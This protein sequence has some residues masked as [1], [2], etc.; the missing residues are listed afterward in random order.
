MDPPL[1]TYESAVKARPWH[2]IEIGA[3][4]YGPFADELT[5]F[6]RNTYLVRK[7]PLRLWLIINAEFTREAQ[8]GISQIIVPLNTNRCAQVYRHLCKCVHS[9][10][11]HPQIYEH[12]ILL[13]CTFRNLHA[14]LK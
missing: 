7:I 8:E 12:F 9:C 6:I 10:K 1:H 11:C 3:F 2:L 5:E 14:F 4:L 13:V